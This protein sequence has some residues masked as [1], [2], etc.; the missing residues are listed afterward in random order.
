MSITAFPVLAR[1]LIDRR[2]LK[3]TIGVLALS[4]AAVD[5]VT[6]WGLLAIA[7]AVAAGGSAT[8]AL[9]VLGYAF[10]FC[11]GMA[12]LARPLLSRVSAAYDEAGRVPAGWISAICA[13]VLVSAFL[14]M[15]AGVAAIF[16]AFVMGLVMPRR[17]DLSH[18]VSRRLEEFISIV[19]LPLF[20]VVSGLKT[21]VG[22]LDRPELW[23][24]TFA[25]I[26]VAIA[27]KW[28]A[29]A[30]MARVAGYSWME[31]SA[32]GAAEH[33]RAD[34]A[35]RPEHRPRAGR[36][37]ARAVLDA[38]RDGARDHVHDRAGAP[39]HRPGRL[40]TAPVESEF[41]GV[42]LEAAGPAILVA[43][44]SEENVDELLALAAP[45]ALSRD[46]EELIVAR[47]LPPPRATGPSPPRNAS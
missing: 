4:C 28:L 38:G 33:P 30:G 6:A 14:S 9:P 22:L 36:D 21:D 43:P 12:F 45:L 27:G 17:A 46:G 18:D 44:L 37:L 11:V 42:Q 3:R 25:I 32:L 1:I 19:L 31:S 26:G 24:L 8:G 7:S 41:A 29:S 16:G 34:G 40:L 23:G 35:D 2:M 15:K 13:G 5:D 39:L 10:A 20:F 47:L